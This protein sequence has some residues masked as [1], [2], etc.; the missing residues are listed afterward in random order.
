M[1]V[2]ILDNRNKKTRRITKSIQSKKNRSVSF[3]LRNQE[4]NA[5]Y[6]RLN[7]MRNNNKNKKPKGILKNK[8]RK[9]NILQYS[10]PSEYNLSSY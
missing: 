5:A 8:N 6:A 3:N 4:L 1:V 7:S 2:S 9:I 10:Q